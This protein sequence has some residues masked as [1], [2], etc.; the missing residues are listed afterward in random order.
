MTTYIYQDNLESE[1]LLTRK[2]AMDDIKMWAEFFKDQEA[3]EFLPNTGFSST[4][5]HAKHWVEK[6]LN[7]YADNQFG[8]QVLIDKKTKQIIGQC[9][10]LKQSVDEQAEIEVGY[11]IF[12]KHWGQG[13]AP[14][15]AKLFID[16]AFHNDLTNSV[17]SIINI[18]NVKSQRVADKNGLTKEKQTVWSGLDVFIYRIKK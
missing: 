3:I 1:R 11:H 7:R 2:L 15:A 9:G 8:L 5:V 6:Q 16:Y 14:E 13:Y 10:L 18:K 4:D 12:K 17:T